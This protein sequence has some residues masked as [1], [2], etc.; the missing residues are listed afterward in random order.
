MI[1]VYSPH[2]RDAMEYQ[3][4]TT[5]RIN[6][7]GWLEVYRGTPVEGQLVAAYADGGWLSVDVVE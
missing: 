5:I 3:N 2:I 1:K 4:A 7:K 6:P